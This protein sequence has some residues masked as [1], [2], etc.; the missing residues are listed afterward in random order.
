[1]GIPAEQR[2]HIFGVFKR[3]HSEAEISGAGIGLA[4]CRVGVGRLGGRIWVESEFGS[5]SVFK[6]SLPSAE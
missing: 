1:M 5:G 3:L 2:D 4:I 6:F